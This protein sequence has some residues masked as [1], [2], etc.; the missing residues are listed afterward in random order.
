M[1]SIQEL[2]ERALAH[3][4]QANS[5]ATLDQARVQYLGKSGE[6]T[7]QMKLLGGLAP[8]E[9]KPFGQA[10]NAAKTR[11]EEALD[12]RRAALAETAKPPGPDLDVTLPGRRRWAGRV[13][14]ITAT[15]ETMKKILIGLG[16]SYDDY[17]DVETEFYNFDSL[18]TP[19][20]HP[21]RDLHDTFYLGPGQLLRTHTTAYQ[22]RGMQASGGRVPIRALHTARGCRADDMDASRY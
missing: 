13:H 14:P 1:Q 6:L 16:F 18:N 11:I 19:S 2:V 15:A 17:P 22:A 5:A 7:G 9:R 20:W 12:Q 4:G 21:A 3:I 10:V 8:E